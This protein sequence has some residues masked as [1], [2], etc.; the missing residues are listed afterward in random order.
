MS[1]AILSTLR[2]VRASFLHAGVPAS[3]A[4][5]EPR[6]SVGGVA[7]AIIPFASAIGWVGGLAGG[8]L[9]AYHGYKRNDSVGWAIGWSILG[10]MFWPIAL[11]VMFAQGL[12][13][14]KSGA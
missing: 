5:A 9:G 3:T 11:P 13:E 7:D 4:V 12:G 1:H 14:P 2:T 6:T 10:G 8:V